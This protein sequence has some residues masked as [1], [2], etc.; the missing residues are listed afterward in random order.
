[1]VSQLKKSNFFCG[2]PL[3]TCCYNQDN[4]LGAFLFEF[5]LDA[6]IIKSAVVFA[7]IR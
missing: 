5:T 7:P 4:N 2:K 6:V 3:S 1:M